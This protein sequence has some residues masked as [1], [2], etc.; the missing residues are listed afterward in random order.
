MRL[1]LIS[2]ILWVTSRTMKKPDLYVWLEQNSYICD[3]SLFGNSLPHFLS[4]DESKQFACDCG[5]PLISRAACARRSNEMPNC[6]EIPDLCMR[7]Y[8]IL[9]TET[10]DRLAQPF[11]TRATT[12]TTEPSTTRQPIP[13]RRPSARRE[14][15]F[16]N[17]VPVRTVTRRPPFRQRT[18]TLQN[19][20]P[21]TRQP[22]R[23][24]TRPLPR[25]LPSSRFRTRQRVQQQPQQL[26]RRISVNFFAAGRQSFN[27]GRRPIIPR[28]PTTTT[29][30]ST[31]T[32]T[33]STTT[34]TTPTTTPTTTTTT[35]ATTTTQTTTPSTTTPTT[36]TTEK[37]TTTTKPTTTTTKATTTTTP[38][39]TTTTR[40]TT[41]PTTTTRKSTTTSTTPKR[42]TTTTA[43]TPRTT[44][45]IAEVIKI[46]KT[47]LLI[48]ELTNRLRAIGNKEPEHPF[49]GLEE[50]FLSRRKSTTTT[51]T[52]TATTTTT[53]ST[54]Q[55]TTT[56]PKTTK[57]HEVVD[58]EVR[59]ESKITS[60]EINTREQLARIEATIQSG[61]V[62]M[63]EL[64]LTSNVAA[65][66]GAETKEKDEKK[67]EDT[68][69]NQMEMTPSGDR[70]RKETTV[71]DD[72]VQTR[73]SP[74]VEGKST[75]KD[76]TGAVPGQKMTK[77]EITKISSMNQEEA[78]EFIRKKLEQ[79]EVRFMETFE[80][81]AA[82][83]VKESRKP[84]DLVASDDEV[85]N[86]R[87]QSR[88]DSRR[89]NADPEITSAGT[90]LESL[91]KVETILKAVDS[92]PE[93]G[94]KTNEKKTKVV[95]GS[96]N[97]TPNPETV[98]V[99]YTVTESE[100]YTSVEMLTNEPETS[101]LRSK[102]CTDTHELCPTWKTAKLCSTSPTFMYKFC[103]EAC[104]FC[105]QRE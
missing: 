63:P 101:T 15:V 16:R 46:S 23:Q 89:R 69:E 36:T 3:L 99:T 59:K 11:T 73:G 61:P 86:I 43:T 87:R 31:T 74:T 71:L 51:A 17:R 26:N 67:N 81:G 14:F 95:E 78:I 24:R 72:P 6:H 102:G 20:F 70:N 57:M 5:D 28:R 34:T 66:T 105:S 98:T 21:L 13:P 53:A 48:A 84:D 33:T 49:M 54:T 2:S 83:T 12:T 76:E 32:T 10:G 79:L 96:G 37:T 47:E 30:T 92:K 103:Q 27:R 100:P 91:D 104:G 18:F 90:F 1:L 88:L 62:K 93:E 7:E 94:H 35:K 75:A 68:G 8:A 40:T 29:T 42:T 22:P 50:L 65:A 56:T 45:N 97:E 39:P 77:T 19:R 44:T 85:V 9:F 82:P 58:D 25:L 80:R 64:T 60:A 52:T 41:R 38:K 4:P 55:A